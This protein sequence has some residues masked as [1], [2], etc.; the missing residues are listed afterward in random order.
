MLQRTCCLF[1][2]MFICFSL[3]EQVEKLV[4]DHIMPSL[5]SNQDRSSKEVTS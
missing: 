1:T 2:F 5:G 3:A 4:Q